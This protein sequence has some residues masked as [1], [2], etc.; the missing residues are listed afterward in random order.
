MEFAPLNPIENAAL[1][2]LFVTM[3]RVTALIAGS[4]TLVGFFVY[5]AGIAW[6]GNEEARRRARRREAKT[7]PLPAARVTGRLAA[8][9]R[10]SA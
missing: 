8:T 9:A 5:L 1:L 6:L 3:I 7:L 10:H 2:N 4:F